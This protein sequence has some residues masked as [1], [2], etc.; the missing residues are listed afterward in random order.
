MYGGGG[1]VPDVFVPIDTSVYTRSVTRLYLDGRFNNFVYQYYI[2]N[3]ETFDKF[4]T[5]ADFSARYQNSEDAWNKLVNFAIRDSINLRNIPEKDKQ[6]IQD[7][8]KAYIARLK[9]RTEG[10]YQ[11]FNKYDPAVIKAKEILSK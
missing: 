8:I 1:I 7:Q 5:P 4:K 10:Y 6:N 9:W 2:N 3:S 11:V